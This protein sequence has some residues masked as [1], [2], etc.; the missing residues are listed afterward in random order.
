[1]NLGLT[2]HHTNVILVRHG[3]EDLASHSKRRHAVVIAFFSVGQRQGD[4]ASRHAQN[5]AAAAVTWQ[6][7]LPATSAHRYADRG[8]SPDEYGVGQVGGSYWIPLAVIVRRALRLLL[9]DERAGQEGD[10]LV[11]PV[12]PEV[13]EKYGVGPGEQEPG[14]VVRRHRCDVMSAD[15][16]TLYE[17]V[18]CCCEALDRD[19]PNTDIRVEAGTANRPSA[20]CKPCRTKSLCSSGRLTG[21]SA[22][23]SQTS[24]P[25]IAE[26]P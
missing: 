15:E 8:S 6:P 20:I 18:A 7:C 1:M 21:A 17:C 3:S 19:H 12:D 24:L 22:K 4:R 2:D 9:L 5:S 14:Y 16:L 26:Y 13:S 25:V 10:F 23:P 11:E